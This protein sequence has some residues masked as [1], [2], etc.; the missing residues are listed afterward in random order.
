MTSC[1]QSLFAIS[2]RQR[3]Q[4]QTASIALFRMRFVGEQVL[5]QLL[6]A[7][8]N[9]GSPGEKASR[10]PGRVSAM[11]LGHMLR[12]SRVRAFALASLVNSNTLP[13]V[14]TFDHSLTDADIDLP[15]YQRV[16]HAVIMT[17]YLDMIIKV[18]AGFAPFGIF[19]RLL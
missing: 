18:H 8:T 13:A 3:E 17:S 19:V 7:L 1:F 10:R 2:F 16:R 6:S 12:K 14:K 9:L 11:S 4:P 15:F 5:D